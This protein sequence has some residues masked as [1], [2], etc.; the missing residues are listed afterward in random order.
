M[1]RATR[2]FGSALI[3]AG[4]MFLSACAEAPP[5]GDR[6]PAADTQAP[7]AHREQALLEDLAMANRIFGQQ[8]GILDIQ[9]HV[10]VRSQTDPD[11]Y[12]ISRYLSPGAVTVADLIENDLDSHAVAGPRTDQASETHLH[13][14]IYKARPDVMAIVHAHTPELVAFG[15]SS[16]PLWHGESRVPVWDIRR[17]NEGRT[18]TVQTPV[19]GVAMAEEGLGSSDSLLL[20]GHGMAVTASSLQEL[21][22]RAIDLRATAR[23]QQTVIA[24]GGT[25]NP[26]MRRVVLQSEAADRSW[27]Y[28]ERRVLEDLAG[29]I[30][31]S[32]PPIPVRSADPDEAAMHDLVLANRVLASEEVAIL[33]S[34]GHVSVRSPSDPDSYFI[35][36]DVSAGVVSSEDIV[37][38]NMT[39][40]G[41][42][43]LSI[44]AEVYR[45]RP[46]VMSIIYSTAP[47]LAVLSDNSVTLRPVVNGGGFLRDGFP[48]FDIGSLDPQQ[49]ILANPA[50]GRGVADALG[51]SRGV[52]LVG[53]GFVLAGTSIYG[54][55]NQAYAL[56]MNALI[57]QQA[58]ALGGEVGHLDDPPPPP[59][60]NAQ[61][62]G[63]RRP[64]PTF[65]DGEAAGEGRGWVYWR[66]NVTLN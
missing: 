60:P 6:P 32:P 50:L 45:A 56:R 43:G 31:T 23:R 52:L 59:A 35:A 30:P 13:G 63:Q 7:A 29:P 22:P 48:V 42:R 18:G 58:I 65:P 15:M 19:L 38:R 44:H 9:G 64:R 37:R 53:H 28:L 36:P 47:E 26:Q 21:V 51:D 4:A 1:T 8:V 41:A 25:W 66:Q 14:Q 62:S 16:V 61:P 2:M 11:H 5:A 55:A 27:D 3:V 57:Q 24:M 17:Y 34:F 12:Y 40:P 33:D 39:E 20:W 49:P 54:L 46:D 10:S